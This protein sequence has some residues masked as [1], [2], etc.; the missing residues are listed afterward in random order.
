MQSFYF[1][2]DT[3]NLALDISWYRFQ[4][5]Y[6]WNTFITYFVYWKSSIKWYYLQIKI[7]LQDKYRH[8]LCW[9]ANYSHLFIQGRST[10]TEWNAFCLLIWE[11]LH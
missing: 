3:D 5:R 6:E 1:R 2:Y 9:S 7:S 10:G 8:L 11:T 4:P